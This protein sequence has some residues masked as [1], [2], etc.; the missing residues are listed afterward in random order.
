[1]PDADCPHEARREVGRDPPRAS[2]PPVAPPGDAS[3]SSDSSGGA[4]VSVFSSILPPETDRALAD[5]LL[6]VVGRAPRGRAWKRAFR[7]VLR[8]RPARHGGGRLLA[9]IRSAVLRA[10][11]ENGLL[12]CM[13]HFEFLLDVYDV[14]MAELSADP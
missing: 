2:N 1:M 6:K 3:A 5:V 10:F 11:I 8:A 9:Q 4:R 7:A 12:S 14:D 13:D